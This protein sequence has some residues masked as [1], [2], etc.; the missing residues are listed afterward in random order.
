MIESVLALLAATPEKLRREI[1]GLTPRE[2]KQRPA[3]DKW[4]IQ[5]I[6]ARLADVEQHGMRSRVE[7]IVTEDRPVL[8]PFDQEKRAIELRYDR[9]D[10]RKSLSSLASQRRANVRWLR[11]LRPA[12]LRR[13]G[14]HR[15][16]GEVSVLEFVHEWA[17]HDLGHMRQIIDVK[18]YPLFAKM[19]NMQKFYNF[20]H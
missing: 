11:K 4:S 16:I 10:P 1:E 8:E 20:D 17:F 18:R 5:E 2:L 7:A 14:S 15:Q 3:P 13:V 12:D 6:L 19:G 9:T